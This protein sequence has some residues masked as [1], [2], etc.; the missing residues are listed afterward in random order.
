MQQDDCMA[1]S[2]I[3]RSGYRGEYSQGETVC[4]TSKTRCEERGKAES[5][6]AAEGGNGR[7]DALA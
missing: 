1:E 6:Q 4:G 3:I 2:I 5:L 7:S